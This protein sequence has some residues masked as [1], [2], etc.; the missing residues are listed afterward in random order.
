[1]LRIQVPFHSAELFTMIANMIY[2]KRRL[3]TL[4]FDFVHELWRDTMVVIQEDDE[5]QVSEFWKMESLF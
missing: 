2:D 3:E 5:D 1:M 4:Q